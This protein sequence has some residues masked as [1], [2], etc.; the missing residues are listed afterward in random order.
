MARETLLFCGDWRVIRG[1]RLTKAGCGL[2]NCIIYWN[3]N[4]VYACELYSLTMILD[5]A[6][7]GLGCFSCLLVMQASPYFGRGGGWERMSGSNRSIFARSNS[8]LLTMIS[9]AILSFEISSAFA[10]FEVLK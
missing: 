5:R 7:G 1:Q 6:S 3:W 9:A 10:K 4:S 2:L 8:C